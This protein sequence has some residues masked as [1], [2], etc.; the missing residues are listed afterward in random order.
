MEE[1]S[2]ERS[3]G[4]NDRRGEVILG[5]PGGR[6]NV[7]GGNDKAHGGHENILGASETVDPVLARNG[8]E[9]QGRETTRG[10]RIRWEDPEEQ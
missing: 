2:D 10:K 8:T 1:A 9:E 7:P 5:S 4:K 6:G 3:D